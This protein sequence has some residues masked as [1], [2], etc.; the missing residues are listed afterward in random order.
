LANSVVNVKWDANYPKGVDDLVDKSPPPSTT[1]TPRT[2]VR[3]EV[4][5]IGAAFGPSSR[6]Y[7]VRGWVKTTASSAWTQIFLGNCNTFN[8]Q[9]IVWSKVLAVG[10]KLDFKFQG[11][12]DNTYNLS[13]VSTIGQWQTAIDTTASSPYSWNRYALTDGETVQNYSPAFD[14]GDLHSHLKAYFEPSSSKLKL[15][16]RDFIFLTELSQ[17]GQ[18]HQSTDMQDLVF[19]VTF[20]DINDANVEDD[21]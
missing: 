20:T 16:P 15:G 21:D 8:P 5:V 11:S 3:A 6:P 9:T 19:L 10:E 2:Q 14:Q 1:L 7:P 4:R 18:N 12:M 13:D 17:F